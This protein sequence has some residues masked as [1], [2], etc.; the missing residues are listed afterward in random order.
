MGILGMEDSSHKEQVVF[1]EVSAEMGERAWFAGKRTAL[2]PK[3]TKGRVMIER[4][5]T[6]KEQRGNKES[7]IDLPCR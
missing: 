2:C 5:N 6:E 1:L 4:Q 7:S 3:A